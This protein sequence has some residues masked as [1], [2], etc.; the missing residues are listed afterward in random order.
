MRFSVL[1]PIYNVEQYLRKCIDSI[2]S[3]TFKDF[4]LLLVIDGSLDNS[5]NICYEYEEVDNRVRVFYKDNEGITATRKFAVNHCEG[6]Y[7]VW[8]DGDDY[9]DSEILYKINRCIEQNNDP[10]VISYGY[11]KHTKSGLSNQIL[12]DLEEKE[13]Q[14]NSQIIGN[15]LYNPE[16]KSENTGVFIFSVWSKCVK[17]LICQMATN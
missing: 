15:F 6:E 9:I 12:N 13:Y 1:V 17:R 10:D 14:I 11:I 4:E 8:V 16:K 7:V 5:L 2:L 3:Q